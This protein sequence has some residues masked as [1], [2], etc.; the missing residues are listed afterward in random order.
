MLLSNHTV[1]IKDSQYLRPLD[2]EWWN[3]NKF[4]IGSKKKEVVEN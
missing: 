2:V 4:M 1:S 3:Y